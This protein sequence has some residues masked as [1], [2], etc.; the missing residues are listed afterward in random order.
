MFSDQ[1][2]SRV[3]FF[4]REDKEKSINPQKFQFSS[5]ADPR[6]AGTISGMT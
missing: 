6:S 4:S 3:L 1:R 5:R 2:I